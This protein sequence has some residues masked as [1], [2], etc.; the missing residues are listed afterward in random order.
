MS[1]T[2]IPIV[3]ITQPEVYAET[4]HNSDF[5]YDPRKIV[6]LVDITPRNLLETTSLSVILGAVDNGVKCS[7]QTL[8]QLD[9]Y[10]AELWTTENLVSLSVTI[11][12]LNPKYPFIQVGADSGRSYWIPIFPGLIKKSPL[13]APFNGMDFYAEDKDLYGHAVKF[14]TEQLATQKLENATKAATSTVIRS[15]DEIGRYVTART[16]QAL[17]EELGETTG[18]E[19]FVRLR[20]IGLEGGDTYQVYEKVVERGQVELAFRTNSGDRVAIWWN[21]H[22]FERPLPGSQSSPILVD[23][24]K[25][26]PELYAVSNEK[27]DEEEP[28]RMIPMDYKLPNPIYPYVNGTMPKKLIDLAALCDGDK[29]LIQLPKSIQAIRNYF[30]RNSSNL[31][32]LSV[33]QVTEAFIASVGKNNFGRN[34]AYEGT[35]K[36]NVLEFTDEHGIRSVP[37]YASVAELDTTP[38]PNEKVK[39]PIGVKMSTERTK[40]PVETVVEPPAGSGPAPNE[41][42]AVMIP[43]PSLADDELAVR[44]A[45]CDLLKGLANGKNEIFFLGEGEK[46]IVS[47]ERLPL[48]SPTFVL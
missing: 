5:I 32:D 44:D 37:L 33:T 13:F 42:V 41:K 48:E 20:E 38:I 1:K 39:P 15:P 43:A 6:R 9:F 31:G 22:L 18:T 29:V 12:Y 23:A 36:G 8:R 25:Q 19:Q 47:V 40:A 10:M 14:I 4:L 3:A 35:R 21:E 26:E 45:L 27:F 30:Y 7:Q 34:L 11:R 46:M 28:E 24:K 17:I 2:V 16:K